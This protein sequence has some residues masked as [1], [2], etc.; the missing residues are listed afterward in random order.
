MK[1]YAMENKLLI[2]LF[3]FALAV[4]LYA[5]T[6]LP[7]RYLSPGV[8]AK[9]YDEL[10]VNLITGKGY[11]LKT[12]A[13]MA[14]IETKG[15]CHRT[16]WRTPLYPLFLAFIYLIFGHSYA[17]VRVIQS[18]MGALLC[19][20]IYFIAKR[21]FNRDIAL[22]ST[23]LL[24]CYKPF[25]LYAYWGGPGFL[26][27][28]NLFTF[29]LAILMLF[30]LDAHKD[31][32]LKTSLISG[33]LIGLISLTRPVMALF[34]LFLFF[35]LLIRYHFLNAVKKI[36][37]LI[38]IFSALIAPWAIR[39]YFVHKAFIPFSTEGGFVLLAGNN[40]YAKGGGLVTLTQF[41]HEE[42]IKNL[43]TMSE[44]SRDKMYRGQAVEFILKNY[45][46]LPKL[47][48]RKLLVFWDLYV[49]DYALDSSI[50]RKYNIWYS[51]V[52]VFCLVWLMKQK[53]LKAGMNSILFLTLFLYFSLMAVIFSGE[54]RFR[55]PLEPFLMIFSAAGV[56]AIYENFKNKIYSYACLGLIVGLNI[57]FYLNSDLILQLARKII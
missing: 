55:L 5:V 41:L 28:E 25:V 22:L 40:P 20:I 34:P 45:R 56:N 1:F 17:V 50:K 33:V 35:F 16:S 26:F 54:P 44:T 18:V 37:P 10:A 14:F 51:L 12:N 3:I 6:H 30:L 52:F 43:S 31:F 36:I 47:F 11:C 39:N 29:L 19:I 46:S 2:L 32:S 9:E 27:S 21:V 24:A 13:G 23:A 38:A 15:D 8:D 4:R 57:I 49:T 7:L 42:E 53:K 48:F